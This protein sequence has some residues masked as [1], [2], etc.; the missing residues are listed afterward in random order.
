M[1]KIQ[2]SLLVSFLAVTMVCGYAI[3]DPTS[4]YTGK[5]YNLNIIGFAQCG[6][7]ANQQASYDGTGGC[8]NGVDEVGHPRG[9]VIFVPLVTKDADVLQICDGAA[10]LP[11]EFYDTDVV[12]LQTLMK[13][14]RILV[15]DGD[16]IG[17]IDKDGTDGIAKFQIPDGDYIVR[18]RA[19]GK[20]SN[21]LQDACMEIDTLICEYYD[22]T[23]ESWESTDCTGFDNTGQQDKWVLTGYIEVRREKGNKDR[24]TNVTGEML[25]SDG[26]VG[27]DDYDDFMWVV[28][29]DNLRLLQ[30]RF[31]PMDGE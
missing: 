15:S 4:D 1:K 17:V 6:K 7:K 28:Y 29:N 9:H 14:V 10:E 22:T 25:P 8:Y 2:F 26:R 5:H 3:A 12:P 23:T 16:K 30:L 31:Y 13:G 18:A 21:E 24:W 19:Q 27:I 11:N 20:P